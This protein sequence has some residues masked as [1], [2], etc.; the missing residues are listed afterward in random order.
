VVRP[1]LLLAGFAA[2]AF[3][4]L[5]GC[6][7]TRVAAVGDGIVTAQSEKNKEDQLAP[8]AIGKAFANVALDDQELGGI[9]GGLSIGSGVVLNFAFQEAT[10]VNHNLTQNI[11]I[12]TITVSP[13]STT[14]SVAGVTVAGSGVSNFSPSSVAGVGAL[15]T[16]VSSPGLA[17]QSIL[18]SGMTQVVSSVGGGGVTNVISN[19]ANYQLVQQTITAN[20][21][22]S[23][24]SQTVQQSVA[25]TVLSR[26]QGA[27]SQFR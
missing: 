21:N 10:F 8:A 18:N 9:R 5:G 23:G 25:S 13:G 4:A 26:V 1:T 27:T 14:A 19:T 16:Q 15:A 11:V 7:D 24:L 17:V 22:I 3:G 20:I 2:I 12:P 6:S